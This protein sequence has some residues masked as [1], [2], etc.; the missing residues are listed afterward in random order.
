MSHI[1]D[2][3][4][5]SCPLP[6]IRAQEALANHDSII[7]IVQDED[8]RDNLKGMASGM[9]CAVAEEIKVDGT[10]LTI[11]KNT[12]SD[13]MQKTVSARKNDQGVGLALI[14]T[15]DRM[16]KGDDALGEV[17][18]KSFFHTVAE[19]GPKPE[20]LVFFNTGVK[21]AIEGSAVLDDLAA[22]EKQG[23]K[24]LCCGT[25]LDYF[26]AKDKLKVGSVSN[27]YAIKEIMFTAGKLVTI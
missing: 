11:A 16:G 18:I 27:M 24:I 1:V 26:K 7:V 2:V 19:T 12:V 14:V 4:G 10:Y 22:L 13:V 8:V 5:L 23:C 21:L 17:L 6:I 15:Q 3:R 9:Q 20:V 25:C